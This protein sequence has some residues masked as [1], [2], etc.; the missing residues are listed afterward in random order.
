MA[1]R[2]R[3]AGIGAGAVL[4]SGT[5]LGAA[6]PAT[7]SGGGEHY[8]A[9]GDSYTAGPLIPHHTG[10]PALCLRSDHN[11]PSLVADRIDAASFTDASCSGA[12]T[13]DMT[14]AQNLGAGANAP[15]FDALKPDTTLVTLGIGGNDIGFG[16]IVVTCGTLSVG[17]PGGAPCK[18][19]Y[20]AGGSDQIADAIADTGPKITR[21]LAGIRKRSPHARVV[22]V[23]YPRILPATGPGCWPLVPI[24]AG[25]VRYLAKEEKRLNGMLA[26]RAHDAG[27]AYAVNYKAGHDLCE[28]PSDK[29]V[30]GVIPTMPAAPIHPNA[31]GMRAVAG[32]VGDAVDGLPASR[33]VSSTSSEG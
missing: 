9:L 20:T 28:A 7:A 22:V 27:A 25:D 6:G 30:E 2:G 13:D 31:D 8:V 29:W 10:H 32:A 3:L 18:K 5:L 33:H 19:K 26:D 15:Q 23:G 4:A 21:A 12:T 11:Y 16:S 24:A 14:S 1:L 17:D